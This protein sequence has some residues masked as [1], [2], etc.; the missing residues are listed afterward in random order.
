MTNPAQLQ[1]LD[2]MGIPV[3]VSRDLVQRSVQK[4]GQK[5][6]QKTEQGIESVATQDKTNTTSDDSHAIAAREHVGS[7][8]H[9]LDAQTQ[10][11]TTQKSYRKV[12]VPQ[13]IP[14]PTPPATIQPTAT[15]P[16]TV[17][18]SSAYKSSQQHTE[19]GRTAVHAIYA[20]GDINADWMVIGESPDI[21]TNGQ[22]QPY[23][24]DSGVILTNMLQAVGISQPRSQ[25]YLVNIL[26]SSMQDKASEE[27]SQLNRLLL[28]RIQQVKPKVLLIVGQIA[29][30]NLLNS[31]EPLIILRGRKHIL[32]DLKTS[33]VVTY[34]PSYLLSKPIDKRKAWEDLKLAMSVL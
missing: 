2:A 20:C 1:Y 12:A 7:L 24:G 16:A 21:S 9:D 22:N 33:I 6:G 13:S 17:P 31:N 19:I 32:P 30:Q 26:K 3:W 8:L 5:I 27:N 15:S 10:T 23:A 28:E 14:I 34:Y 29:A 11:H 18:V 25:A 4:I